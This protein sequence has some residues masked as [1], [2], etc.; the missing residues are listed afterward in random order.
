MK[1]WTPSPHDL[2]F[3][4]TD[5]DDYHIH[6]AA[7]HCQADLLLTDNDPRDITT[8]DNVHYE[9]ICPDDFFV[10]VTKSASLR[11]LY[12]ILKDQIAYW[13]QKPEHQQLDEALRRANCTEFAKMVRTALQNMARM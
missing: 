6:A 4:V 11:M 2:E 13:S 8:S 5:E 10:L 1:Y 12:P 7:T 9:I 3:S